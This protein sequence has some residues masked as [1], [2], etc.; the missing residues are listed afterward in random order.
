MV[1]VSALLQ[2]LR[3]LNLC[4]AIPALLPPSARHAFI[5]HIRYYSL[6]LVLLSCSTF[7]Q[8][9]YLV[10]STFE[11]NDF[12]GTAPSDSGHSSGNCPCSAPHAAARLRQS[13]QHRGMLAVFWMPTSSFYQA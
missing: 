9:R 3:A 2:K 6:Y 8:P 10:I 13:E 11:Y 1:G 12:S 4:R 7:R 5:A